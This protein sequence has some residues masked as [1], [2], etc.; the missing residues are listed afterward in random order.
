[1]HRNLLRNVYKSKWEEQHFNKSTKWTSSICFTVYILNI[2]VCVCLCL[3]TK[4]IFAQDTD[5]NIMKMKW[6][7]FIF[8]RPVVVGNSQTIFDEEACKRVECVSGCLSRSVPL[9]LCLSVCVMSLR[10][11][12]DVRVCLSSMRSPARLASV[13]ISI[14][15]QTINNNKDR[16]REKQI[17]EQRENERGRGKQQLPS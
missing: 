2:C 8:S 10:V 17:D 4:Y 15:T 6:T 13:C 9:P 12:S 5:A 14:E 16:Q 3:Y 11:W 1:M 7:N